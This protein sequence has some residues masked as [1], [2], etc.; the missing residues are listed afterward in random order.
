[1][2]EDELQVN[3][4]GEEYLLVQL[5]QSDLEIEYRQ[6]KDQMANLKLMY[7][8]VKAE[9]LIVVVEQREIVVVQQ[10]EGEKQASSNYYLT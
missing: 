5:I 7:Y 1:M 10:M 9:N 2:K 3:R 6:I 4:M 8:G